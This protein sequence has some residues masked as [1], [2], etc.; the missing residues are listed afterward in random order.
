MRRI[1]EK[2][3][4]NP[5]TGK[6][7]PKEES[8]EELSFHVHQF[9]SRPRPKNAKRIVVFSMFGEFGCETLGIMYCL[10]R[11]IKQLNGYYTIAM[12]WHGRQYLYKHL[13]NEYWELDEK[14][15]HLRE[16]ARAFH[17][18]SVN[19]KRLERSVAANHCNQL[20]GSKYFGQMAVGNKC[21]TCRYVWG[22]I[23]SKIEKCPKCGASVDKL[24]LSILGNIPYWKP[25]AT[26]I[27]RPSE[28]KLIQAWKYLKPNSV[29]V[30]ARGREC[31]GRNLQPEF[32]V[33]LISLLEGLGYN[34]IWMGEKATTLP[35]PVSHILDYSRLPESR[36]LEL[37][38]A[39]V[40]ELKFTVQFW[41]ASTRLAGMMGIPYL[42]F[43]SPDQI[44]G[45]GQEGYRRQLCDFGPGKLAVCHFLNV[46][47]D[48]DAGIKVVEQCVKEMEQ[49]NY[50]DVVGVVESAE[51]VMS[52]K[53]GCTFNI[54]PNG[55]NG[56][57]NSPLVGEVVNA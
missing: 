46:F 39:I 50:E 36:D 30:F 37:T 47:N 28:E 10:P 5:G 12:G 35:C 34:P 38:L 16:Y 4:F 20:I 51:A 18:D 55:L 56:L 9:S 32:Y 33:K 11:L 2:S 49:N 6:I 42:V 22:D 41:T 31:Y 29:G 43:E 15:Q 14:H 23:K 25:Q 7:M 27:P 3:R 44:W 40:S 52:M 19:L 24:E 48:N 57:L 8:I 21:N 54:P 17:N 45:Q 13:V 1:L 53:N 26:K